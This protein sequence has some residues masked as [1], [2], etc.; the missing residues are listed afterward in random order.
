MPKRNTEQPKVNRKAPKPG[1][2]QITI[3]F[4]TVLSFLEFL[5][6]AAATGNADITQRDTPLPDAISEYRQP[7]RESEEL[8][9]VWMSRVQQGTARL[10]ELVKELSSVPVP[11]L[12]ALQSA[13]TK[14]KL[15]TRNRAV[16]MLA[17]LRGIGVDS[18][19]NF[20]HVCSTTVF[21]WWRLYREGGAT[22]LLTRKPRSDIKANDDALK[23]AVFALLHSPPSSHGFN[24]TTWRV[25][26]LQVALSKQRNRPISRQ[27]ISTMIRQAGWKWRSARVV[28]TSN[29]PDYRTKVDAIKKILSELKDD[30][31]FFSIDEYGPFAIRQKGGVKLVPPD[32]QYIVPQWQRS[33][34]W[35]IM[36]AALELKRNQITHFYSRKKNT[37]EMIKITDL[38]R[39]QYRSCRTIYLSWD[40]AS[41]HES[42][43]LVAH[44]EMLNQQAAAYGSPTIKTA[45]LPACAQ[46]L[47]VIESVFSGMARA[48]IHNSDYPSIEAAQQAIDRYFSQRNEYFLRHPKR[49][50]QK[51]W[52]KEL[53]PSAFA[54]GQNCK[55]PAHQFLIE[56]RKS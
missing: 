24:R 34:G 33:K 21:R 56:E 46:F 51:I 45:P 18:I 6:C 55:D 52:G 47:N 20:L 40:A 14:G 42:K 17:Y 16:A 35:L 4:E 9:F 10:P 2:L 50:G 53:V 44:L 49:A 5:S 8:A 37:D 3:P 39:T 19:S 13:T 28:L 48:I 43:D 38:L 23:Q 54:E 11:Q 12:E 7:F 41:W 1:A 29:D 15:K 25:A 22:T 26:D 27:V 30:E 36:T 32:G 31:A